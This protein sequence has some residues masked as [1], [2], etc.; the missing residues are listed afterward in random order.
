VPGGDPRLLSGWTRPIP[1][2]GDSLTQIPVNRSY[3]EAYGFELLL[4]KKNTVRNSPLTGW[5]SFAHAYAY[6]FDNGEKLPFRFDQRNTV[7]IVM[8]Y[9][10]NSWFS[11]GM[12]W[13]YGSGFPI[14]EPSGVVP[15]IYYAD[16]DLDGK[17]DSPEIAARRNSA[18]EDVVIYDVNF[19][20][21]KLNSKKP[22]YHRLDIRITAL[23]TS[24]PLT[25]LSIWM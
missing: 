3:G 6:R 20:D 4:A 17:P 22:P 2:S 21:N 18:G 14:S 15:R 24:G 9:Q 1:V 7:N 12:R 23:Q 11:A 8:N 25:G 13:Q 16:T 5:I 19:G 10:V